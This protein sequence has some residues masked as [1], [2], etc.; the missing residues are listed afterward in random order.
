MAKLIYKYPIILASTSKAR[1]ELLNQI[2]VDHQ[3]VAPL[4]DE[5]Q[6]KANFKNHNLFELARHLAQ[7]KAAS[8]SKEYADC[9][10]IAADQI[11]EFHT[12]PFF[13]PG[14]RENNIRMLHQ[15]SGQQHKQHTST[16]VYFNNK[17]IHHISSSAT[18]NM[19]ELTEAEI[20]AYVD[21][22]K[23]W[24]CCGGYRFEGMGKHLFNHVDGDFDN[25][26]GLPIIPLLNFLHAHH[27]LQLVDDEQAIIETKEW[28]EKFSL[29]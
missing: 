4:I 16:V 8:V 29:S 17:P 1:H 27:Y 14:T 5:E 10:V 12:S 3:V 2:H 26:L 25:I 19:R 7:S 18:L 22:D 21:H 23:A 13:K 24:N 15:L 9:I 11:G 20:F 6:L 28:E